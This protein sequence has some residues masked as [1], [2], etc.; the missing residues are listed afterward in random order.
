MGGYG[1][2]RNARSDYQRHGIIIMIKKMINKILSKFFWQR[3]WK[4]IAA[5]VAGILIIALILS[6]L[7]GGQQDVGAQ[8]AG[9]QVVKLAKNIRNRYQSRPDFWGLSTREVIAKKIYPTDMTVNDEALSGYFGN[10]VE[11]GSDKNGTPVMPTIR[12]F[13]IAYNGLSKDQCIALAS[14]RFDQNFWLGVTALTVAND[15]AE[16]VFD[17]TSKDFMLPAAKSS[18]KKIC[19]HK[20]NSV[21][22][23]FE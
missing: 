10:P 4:N 15:N 14:N 5:V 21:I 1:N 23:H 17:W 13:V 8:E 18:L 9:N 16:Q 6:L 3:Q 12:R 7:I 2:I 19:R 20:N 22:F 11:I